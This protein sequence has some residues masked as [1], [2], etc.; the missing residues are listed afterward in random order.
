MAWEV[1]IPEE[2]SFRC[3]G[4]HGTLTASLLQTQADIDRYRR[5]SL[6]GGGYLW[7]ILVALATIA[8]TY[9]WLL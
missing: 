7:F 8:L 3:P 9:W 2:E 1:S 4:C 5:R 6:S